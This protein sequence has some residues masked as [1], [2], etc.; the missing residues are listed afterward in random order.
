M[1]GVQTCALP[2]YEV[3]SEP[4]QD[5]QSMDA[6]MNEIKDNDQNE[7]PLVVEPLVEAPTEPTVMKTKRALRAK[8]LPKNIE[9]VEVPADNLN[10][11]EV[12]VTI[13]D[14]PN[15]KVNCPN[16]NKQMS[17]KTLKYTHSFNCKSKPVQIE[18]PIQHVQHKEPVV[19][20]E[21]LDQ[22]IKKRMTNNREL[23][24]QQRAEKMQSLIKNAF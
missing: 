23:R 4:V 21:M 5:A 18:Q 11:N 20:E 12:T 24:A 19:T 16:C 1:T 17:A 3:V 13:E 9:V 7:V 22:A 15:D 2:I 6:V 8:K 10:D 14:K